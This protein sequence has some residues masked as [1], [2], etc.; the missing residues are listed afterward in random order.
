V[1]NNILYGGSIIHRL[2]GVVRFSCVVA[3]ASSSHIAKVARGFFV[4]GIFD[5]ASGAG[6]AYFAAKK[7]TQYK[8]NQEGETGTAAL[9]LVSG[10]SSIL[11]G[12][13]DVMYGMQSLKW[14][15]TAA[16][17]TRV[18]N[19]LLGIGIV[20]SLV[21]IAVSAKKI[22]DLK[23]EL[24]ESDNK[25]SERFK[26]VLE[27]IDIALNIVCFVAVILLLSSPPAAMAASGILLGITIYSLVMI[28][29]AHKIQQRLDQLPKNDMK[30]LKAI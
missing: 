8:E 2:G 17:V 4:L 1:V 15:S 29:L 21:N 13:S 30:S 18:A 7:I 6:K 3:K 26:I 22:G 23:K 11:C 12:A 27:S 25:K 10:T 14:L 19:T 16:K 5:L 20:F 28:P 24:A 9:A